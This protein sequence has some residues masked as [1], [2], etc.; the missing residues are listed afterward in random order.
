[1]PASTSDNDW[2]MD[3]DL[4]AMTHD[5]PMPE[6]WR[7]NMT[8]EDVL[9]NKHTEFP[10]D[11][12]NFERFVKSFPIE[13]CRLKKGTTQ[14]EQWQADNLRE[15]QDEW[16]PFASE[17][18]WETV[19]WLVTNVGQSAVEEYLK[20][21]ITKSRSKLSFSSRYKLNKKLNK[22]PTGSDWECEPITV[23]GDRVD[24]HGKP[25]TEEI[26]L[27]H[28]NPV[29]CIHEL[30]G[31]PAFK[32]HLAY[33]PEHVFGNI[34]ETNRL[35][36]EMWTAE[37]WWKIQES[38][39]RGAF[40]APVILAS[41]KTQLSNFG[42]DK[43]AWPVYLT[44]GNLSKEIRWR[45]SCHGTVLIGYLPVAKLQCFS[46]SVRSLEI[47]WL[48]HKC[49]SKLVNPLVAA[50]K[51]GVEMTCADSLIWKI[52]PIL[53]VYIADY[54]EQCLVACCKENQCPRCVVPPEER[55]EL[56]ETRHL[57]HTN[58]FTSITP[59]ILHQ[60]HKGVFKDHLVK[61]CTTVIGAD[62]LDARFNAMPDAHGLRHFKKGISGVSQWTG[63]EH[64]EMQK[65]F[66]GVMAGAVNNKV[67]TVVRALVD[68]I[69]Y[70]QF[71]SH[72][73]TSLNSLRV[74]LELFHKHKDIF[75]DLE[76]REHFN[77][78][79]LHAIQH[80]I[81][82]IKEL[83]SLNGYNTESPER[84]HIDFAK[85]AYRASNRHNFLVQMAWVHNCLP[86]L[87]AKPPKDPDSKP[88]T[89]QGTTEDED[90]QTLTQ[91]SPS[92]PSL[93]PA[94]YRI[95]KVA[96]F[97]RMV[98]EL[99]TLHGAIDF[100]PALST[101]LKQLN[102][103][104]R[105]E[106]S[107]YDRFNVYKKLAISIAPN[108]FLSSESRTSQLWATCAQPHEGCKKPM[109]AHFDTALVIEDLGVY[110]AKECLMEQVRVAQIRV[111]FLLPPQFSSHP[112]PLA[113][114]EW[115]TLLRHFDTT[116]GMYI[117]QQS[118]HAHHHN[119]SIVSIEQLVRSCHL[120]AK[121]NTKI[122]PDWM[123]DNV[124]DNAPF[125]YLN[126]HFDIGLFS[127]IKM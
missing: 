111:I 7:C 70:A 87:L 74:S 99:E 29:K 77:I 64:K 45:P 17:A 2:T 12:H 93:T 53:A 22:L 124:L 106:P 20:L 67:L 16:Y 21:D 103:K 18:E 101:F 83:G 90:E 108:R 57:P 15:G 1:M 125:L 40:V 19:H 14:F 100:V 97:R 112:T 107:C 46:K 117:I 37:W 60:L 42:S 32:D 49:M 88:V 62:E 30:I 94:F 78:P 55:G 47:Y 80:Y 109:P 104:S 58:I 48:F 24:R 115:F 86:S 72:T 54:P 26:E 79:K 11:S 68:F 121:C 6:P 69:Y 65:V 92:T 61:W 36:D 43:S 81:D 66:V 51:Q 41:D 59:D 110:K 44:I 13:P 4:V 27:W 105:I 102:P 126:S 25:L 89:K 31:N 120:M 33:L 91:P 3:V 76:I 56:L 123:S 35:Y 113:Y 75:V 95:A 82:S 114:V 34:E 122:D 71:Q 23:K 38:M 28:R 9:G 98:A 63:K 119:T 85:E 5:T 118:T 84:L 39:P 50:G 10:N 127:H 8:V 52:F 73:T 96:P 116:T